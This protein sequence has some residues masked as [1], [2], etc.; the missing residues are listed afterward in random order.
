MMIYELQRFAEDTASLNARY[1]E[2]VERCQ[3]Y[4]AALSAPDSWAVPVAENADG[5][6]QY[7]PCPLETLAEILVDLNR[8]LPEDP[9]FRHSRQPIRPLSFLEIGCG[10]GRNLN[11]VGHQKLV[12]VSKAV[13]FDIIPAYIEVAQ[14]LYGLGENVFVQDAMTFDYGGFD[15]VFF[16]RPFSDDDLETAFEKYLLDSVKPG[17][18]IIGMN[19]EHLDGSRRVARFGDSGKL[20]KKL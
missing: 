9:D 14:R 20:F 4:E 17:A 6:Y 11:L 7:I 10:I 13:G 1:G 8:H 15:L 3:I 2:M 18:V 19:A 16:Y 12:P 5:A